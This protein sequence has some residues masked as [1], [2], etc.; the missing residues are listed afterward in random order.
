M[1]YNQCFFKIIRKIKEDSKTLEEIRE[2]I[3]KLD[4]KAK[5]LREFRE[6]N[7][8]A[9]QTAVELLLPTKHWCSE[10]RLVIGS[11]K[12][13]GEGRFGFIDIFV[14]GVNG[15]GLSSSII[16]ELKCISLVGLLS[17]EKGRWVDNPD[18]KSLMELD[19]KLEKEAENELLNRK[20]FYWCKEKKK[21]KQVNVKKIISGG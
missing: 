2:F 5:Y 13:S 21:C 8:V 9:F 1:V 17:G 3:S 4:E 14:N 7:E 16:L 20:Y 19:A 12:I 18:Y 10:L 6:Y 11:S 15:N